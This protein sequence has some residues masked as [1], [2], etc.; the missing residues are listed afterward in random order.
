MK[1]R[2]TFHRVVAW[3]L[4]IFSILTILSGYAVSR[5]WTS[6]RQLMVDAHV[7]LK[8][9]FVVLFLIH[10]VYTFAFVRIGKVIRQNPRKHKIRI[11]Q[12]VTKWLVLLFGFLIILTGFSDYSWA[13]A[14]FQRWLPFWVHEVFDIGLTISFIAHTMAGVKIITRRNKIEKTCVD[15]MIWIVGIILMAGTIFLEVT[16]N[17]F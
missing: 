15:V 13:S 8:W 14:A 16:M 7:V 17:L 6:N 3:W 10:I 11:V 4:V 1:F 5:N 9:S 2:L 12:S